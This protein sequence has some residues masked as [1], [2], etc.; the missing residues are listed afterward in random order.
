MGDRLLPGEAARLLR[1]RIE[2]GGHELFLEGLTRDEA[3]ALVA[4][5]GAAREPETTAGAPLTETKPTRGAP[6]SRSATSA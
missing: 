6:E 4:R 3:L 2:M 1:Q 5:A